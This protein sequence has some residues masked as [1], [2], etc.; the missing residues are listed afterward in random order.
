MDFQ[1]EVCKKYVLTCGI[2]SYVV[3]KRLNSM[4]NSLFSP[5]SFSFSSVSACVAS[6]LFAMRREKIRFSRLGSGIYRKKI[7]YPVSVPGF[8]V[9]PTPIPKTGFFSGSYVC[10]A[11]TFTLQKRK[12]HCII[13]SLFPDPNL[14]IE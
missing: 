9:I 3:I 11:F 6:F 7:R 14:K 12:N 10:G 8:G 5:F 13:K 1:T 4:S 2:C